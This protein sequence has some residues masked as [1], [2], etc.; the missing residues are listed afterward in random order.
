MKKVNAV[1]IRVTGGVSLYL[2]LGHPIIISNWL[3]LLTLPSSYT[4][5]LSLCKDLRLKY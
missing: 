4:Y 2:S 1:L 3:L 5:I